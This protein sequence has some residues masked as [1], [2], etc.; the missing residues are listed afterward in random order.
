M[1]DKPVNKSGSL[2]TI[3]TIGGLTA[4]FSIT[5]SYNLHSMAEGE[6]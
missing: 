6:P 3:S 1:A 4:W 5:F 2:S